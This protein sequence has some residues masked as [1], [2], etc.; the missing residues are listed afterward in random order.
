[1]PPARSAAS[2]CRTTS[3]TRKHTDP[4]TERSR[5]LPLPGLPRPRRTSVDDQ[6][7]PGPAPIAHP[8]ARLQPP[9]HKDNPCVPGTPPITTSP[10]PTTAPSSSTATSS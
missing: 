5:R 3:S 6:G 10:T 9:T 8:S 4:A 1:M 7:G 2:G